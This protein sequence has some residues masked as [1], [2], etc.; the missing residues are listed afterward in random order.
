M[1]RK[2]V[3]RTTP[4]L[5]DIGRAPGPILEKRDI[6]SIKAILAEFYGP[7]F[8]LEETYRLFPSFSLDAPRA[9]IFFINRLNTWHNIPS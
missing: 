9:F 4:I 2:G 1:H 6:E 7:I 8:L 5:L 3:F